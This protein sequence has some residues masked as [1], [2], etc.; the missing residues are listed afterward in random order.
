MANGASASAVGRELGIPQ[1]TVR[2]WARQAGI[3]IQHQ[4]RCPKLSML[5]K[6]RVIYEMLMAGTYSVAQIAAQAGVCTSTV[7]NR[8]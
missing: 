2:R 8:R 6:H 7:Y 1:P 4:S 3:A 5:D